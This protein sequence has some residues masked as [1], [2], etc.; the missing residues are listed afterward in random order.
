[1]DNDEMGAPND[2]P[3]DS[4][5]ARSSRL[6][7]GGHRGARAADGLSDE[8]DQIKEAPAPSQSS[9]PYAPSIRPDDVSVDCGSKASR[10]LDDTL[11]FG[12]QSSMKVDTSNF[13]E[14]SIS[15]IS[16]QQSHYPR[17]KSSFPSHLSF[18]K[19]FF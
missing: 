5:L 8:D 12:A 18:Q 3:G 19:A 13:I 11:H 15:S 4:S 14:P 9:Y 7:P 6:P 2:R 17:C 1:M 16:H 10:L